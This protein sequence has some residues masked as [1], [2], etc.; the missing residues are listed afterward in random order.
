MPFTSGTTRGTPGSRRYAE[1]LSTVTAPP[2]TACGTSSRLAAVPTENRQTSRSPAASASGVASSTVT[3]PI[4]LPAERADAKSRTSS[5]PRSR[6]RSTV[7]VPT[8]PVAPTTP[9][10]GLAKVEGLV[11]G[12]HGPVDVGRGDVTGD[13]D[14]GGRDEGRLDADGLE[15]RERLRRD[16]GVTL[17]AGADEADLPEVVAGAPRHAES[18][19]R[20]RR[21]GTILDRR[22]ED[23]L[24]ARL[25][26]RV[27][28]DG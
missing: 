5:Y 7:T 22:R 21:V 12:L 25:H 24:S 17:H 2:R 8:A 14:R 11:Q 16:A 20:P 23:D 28:V 6:S 13:L 9:M 10:R 19:E 18:F 3:P 4:T 1:D 26:D 15:R 27:D